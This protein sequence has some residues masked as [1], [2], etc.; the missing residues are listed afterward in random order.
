MFASLDLKCQ[1]K[2]IS[3]AKFFAFWSIIA[4]GELSTPLTEAA[5]ITASVTLEG[6]TIHLQAAPPIAQT[7]LADAI[8]VGHDEHLIFLAIDLNDGWKTYW[9]LPG[10]FGLAPELD[11]QASENVVDVRTIFP[12]PS[13][14]DEGDGVSVGYA[15][16]TLWPVVVRSDNTDT[17]VDVHLS[18]Q[19]GLCAE[20]CLPERVELSAWLPDLV[21]QPEIT[22]AQI[23]RLQN[24]LATREQPLHQLSLDHIGTNISILLNTTPAKE[25]FA[26][27]EDEQGRHTLLQTSDDPTQSSQALHGE[28]RWQTPISSVT[29]VAPGNRIDVFSSSL[30]DRR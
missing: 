22:M 23:F 20:V 5:E 17:P 9:R 27:A 25:S 7:L 19:I 1:P 14:F 26:I 10:R 13:L 6:A 18:L 28:W 4:L 29:V 3:T 8:T 15:A 16:P 21:A 11:W 2:L 12:T 30:Q 24:N